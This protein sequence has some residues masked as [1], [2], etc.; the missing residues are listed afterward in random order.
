MAQIEPLTAQKRMPT[1]ENPELFAI[2]LPA[3]QNQLCRASPENA[4]KRKMLS[5]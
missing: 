2:D 4:H 1:A 5:R 3:K